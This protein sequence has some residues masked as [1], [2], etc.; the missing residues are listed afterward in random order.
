MTAYFLSIILILIAR[1]LAGVFAGLLWVMM[2]GYA[3]KMVRDD[4]RDRA[5]I[6][7]ILGVPIALSMCI[8]L[9]TSIGQLI[10]RLTIRGTI[11]SHVLF[12]CILNLYIHSTKENIDNNR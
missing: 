8:P 12:F 11:H 2:V 4:K 7:V 9:G 6:I 5:T 1:F 10:G 3:T